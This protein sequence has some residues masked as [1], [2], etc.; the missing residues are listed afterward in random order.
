MMDSAAQANDD[1]AARPFHAPETAGSSIDRA[2]DPARF[3]Q[4]GSQLHDDLMR[5][6]QQKA[7]LDAS[8]GEQPQLRSYQNSKIGSIGMQADTRRELALKRKEERKRREERFGDKNI[9]RIAE[10]KR[11]SPVA[12]RSFEETDTKDSTAT[13]QEKNAQPTDQARSSPSFRE[14]SSR[15]YN[16]Y[17]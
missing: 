1:I 2:I 6:A 11:R 14:P 15:N 9:G 10:R 12:T 13:R 5:R 17:G 4:S 7:S 3:A 16:P 8:M